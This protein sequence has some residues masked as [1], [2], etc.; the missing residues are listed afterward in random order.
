MVKIG[1]CFDKNGESVVSTGA[2]DLNAEYE[3]KETIETF[4]SILADSGEVIELPWHKNVFNDLK[5]YK[6]D[7]VFNITES[8]NSRNRESYIP[9]YCEILNIPYTGSDGLALGISL[10]KVLT[11]HIACSLGIRTARFT[12]ITGLAD[13]DEIDMEY[14][15]FVKPNNEGSSIGVRQ[16]SKVI[17]QKQ[18]YG[19]VKKLLEL[20]QEPVIVEEFLP[21]REFAVAVLGNNGPEVFPVAE[22]IVEEETGDR[23]SFYSYEFKHLHNKKVVCPA[24]IN[25]KVKQQMVDDTIKIF[26]ELGCRDLARADFKLDKDGNPCFIEINPLPGLSPFYSIYPIQAKAAGIKHKEI[27]KRLIDFA[28]QRSESYKLN[29]R[30]FLKS[31]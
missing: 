21:G 18:L 16:Q 2:E 29:K 9:N 11:K 6:P 23:A 27:F 26:K 25:D 15:L 22:I 31:V 10:D 14:P 19:Q 13:L 28:L 3:S 20:Y 1:F 24:E 4:K 8:N 7:L 17:D 5:K 30:R 12:K